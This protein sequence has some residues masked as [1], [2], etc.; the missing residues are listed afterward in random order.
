MNR[1]WKILA[2]SAAGI[3]LTNSIAPDLS[4]VRPQKTGRRTV[5][6]FAER[7]MDAETP[8]APFCT[9]RFSERD[10]QLY[11]DGVPVGQNM[12][13]AVCRTVPL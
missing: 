1:A 9:I 6:A 11:R 12:R 3:L 2:L 13:N 7:I 5:S 10:Q 8:S 4:F